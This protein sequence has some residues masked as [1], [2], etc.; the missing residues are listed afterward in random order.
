M[1]QY[2]DAEIL[3]QKAAQDLLGAEIL[4]EK[5]DELLD[6]VGFH[7]QQFIEKKMKASLNRHGIVYPRT[8]DLRALLRLFPREDVGEDDVMFLHILSRLAVESRYNDYFAPPLDGQQMFDRAV[9][10]AERIETLWNE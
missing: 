7:L 8:H 4:L 9:S 10:F 5:S 1:A 3:E 2:N 6:L